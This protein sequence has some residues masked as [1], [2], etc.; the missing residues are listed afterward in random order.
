MLHDERAVFETEIRKAINKTIMFFC[1]N[2]YFYDKT[3]EYIRRWRILL[4]Q[5][6]QPEHQVRY[7]EMREFSKSFEKIRDLQNSF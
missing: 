4:N 3:P 7:F 6:F 2:L 5:K 1:V